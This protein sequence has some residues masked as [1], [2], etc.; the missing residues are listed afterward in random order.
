M[1]FALVTMRSM[2][3]DAAVAIQWLDWCDDLC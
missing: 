2:A 1:V 3:V